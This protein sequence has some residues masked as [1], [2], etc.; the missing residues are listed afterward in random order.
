MVNM[1]IAKMTEYYVGKRIKFMG[2]N[3]PYTRLRNGD[4]GTV[5]GVDGLG[6]LD[7]KWD[8]G[9]TLGLI[10]GEDHYELF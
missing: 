2:S 6:T 5:I 10:P 9:S 7:C 8:N 3:D 1:D 4:M